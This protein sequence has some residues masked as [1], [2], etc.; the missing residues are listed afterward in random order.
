MNPITIADR[1]LLEAQDRKTTDFPQ[2]GKSTLLSFSS[3]IRTTPAWKENF[4][5]YELYPPESLFS[6]E[7]CKHITLYIFSNISN[8]A[9]L[10]DIEIT[11][12]PNV[13]RKKTYEDAERLVYKGKLLEL[14]PAIENPESPF[15]ISRYAFNGMGNGY[16]LTYTQTCNDTKFEI[17]VEK[18]PNSSFVFHAGE[19]KR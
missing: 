2:S 16:Y 3:A 11:D 7:T 19:K 13:Y 17:H 1:A 15:I 14:I 12:C 8:I 4:P 18:M 6:N 5:Q 9:F 10:K